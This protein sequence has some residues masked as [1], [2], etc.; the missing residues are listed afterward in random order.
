MCSRSLWPPW[1]S[2]V[3]CRG[4][5]TSSVPDLAALAR[6][7]IPSTSTCPSLSRTHIQH[8]VTRR[9]LRNRLHCFTPPTSHTHNRLLSLD[10]NV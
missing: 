6:G 1:R 10:A 4:V 7:V 5:L 9:S 8:R 2:F 3:L